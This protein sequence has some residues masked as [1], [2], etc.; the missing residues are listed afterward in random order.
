MLIAA[1]A[2]PLCP[3]HIELAAIIHPNSL[4]DDPSPH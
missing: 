1:G 4:D 3:R 2:L